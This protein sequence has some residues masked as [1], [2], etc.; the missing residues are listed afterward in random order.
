L[1]LLFRFQESAD[2]QFGITPRTQR[3]YIKQIKRIERAFGDFP[4]KALARRST[5][6]GGVPRMAR[7]A[8]TDIPASSRLRLW[9]V[10][11]DSFL[12]TWSRTDCKEPV[13]QGR[14]ALPRHPRP[15]DL[16]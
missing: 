12:G 1:A 4:I 8:G 11:T 10:G 5:F 14:Q 16:E 2:F 15:Q 9:H 7:P 6:E 3:D 13:C